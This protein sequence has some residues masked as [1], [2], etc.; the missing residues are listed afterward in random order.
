MIYERI[1][2]TFQEQNIKYTVIGGIAVNLHGY[3]RLTGDLDIIISLDEENIRKFINAVK[4]LGLIPRLP[5]NLDDL[6]NETIRNN[7]INEKRMLV[8]SVY[9]QKY[10]LE[11]IDVKIDDN[12]NI[13]HYIDSSILIEADDI[14][15]PLISIDNL[16]KLKKMAG[17]DRD[18]VDVQ[19]LE[20]IKKINAG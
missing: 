6:A 15:I 7:W 19:A 2:K 9:N 16:I 10:P 3:N 13:E 14:K 12:E 8:F 1:F 20:R 17:R 4:D 5:L 18:L 11:H